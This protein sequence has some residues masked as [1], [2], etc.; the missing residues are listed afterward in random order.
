MSDKRIIALPLAE[1]ITDNDFFV[2]DSSNGGT[3]KIAKGTLF[4]N[5]ESEIEGIETNITDIENEIGDTALPTTAQ[6]LSGAIAEHENDISELNSKFV[7]AVTVTGSLATVKYLKVGKI[8]V[9]NIPAITTSQTIASWGSAEIASIPSGYEPD[10][11]F[12]YVLPRQSA[13][14]YIPVFIRPS[15]GKLKLENQSGSSQSTGVI[16]DGFYVWFTS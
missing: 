9:C 11:E 2:F 8:V 6:T 4:G 14:N 7:N 1:E 3:K 10:G 16:L 13:T 5:I 15:N 12:S